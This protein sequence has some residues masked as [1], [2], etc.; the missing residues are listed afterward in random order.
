MRRLFLMLALVAGD[1]P[2]V[3]SSPAAAPAPGA[4]A[5]EASPEMEAAPAY[6]PA[7][8]AD[9]V[10]VFHGV[11]VRDPYRWMED[12]RS[13]ELATWIEAQNKLSEPQLRGSAAHAEAMARMKALT[14]LYP[15]QEQPRLAGSLM[16]FASHCSRS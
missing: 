4:T 2:A 14:D 7:R 11:E 1:A 12:L 9:V 8:R 13:P 6:P 5:S 15:K 3:D 10:D 16:S